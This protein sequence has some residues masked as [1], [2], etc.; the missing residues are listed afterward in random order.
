MMAAI[1][2]SAMLDPDTVILDSDTLLFS[3]KFTQKQSHSTLSL[4]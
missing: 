1:F 3:L 4:A 2:N